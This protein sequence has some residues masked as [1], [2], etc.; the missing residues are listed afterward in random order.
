GAFDQGT[1]FRITPSGTLTTLVSLHAPDGRFPRGGLVA[2]GD[3]NFY[4]TTFLGGVEDHGTVFKVTPT[5][6]LT[7]LSSFSNENGQGP[8]GGLVQAGDG[9]FYGTAAD[10]GGRGGG[11]VFKVTPSGALTTVLPFDIYD[12]ARRDFSRRACSRDPVE[13]STERPSWA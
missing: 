1:V 4:G 10:D 6:T 8:V 9:S 11:S 7:T 3:G 12:D 13:P 2:G 5:G